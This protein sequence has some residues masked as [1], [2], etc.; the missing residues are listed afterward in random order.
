M[1]SFTLSHQYEMRWNKSTV[2]L[3]II[4]QQYTLLRDSI[5]YS[6]L[7]LIDIDRLEIGRQEKE[8]YGDSFAGQKIVNLAQPSKR[9]GQFFQLQ[10]DITAQFCDSLQAIQRKFSDTK[11]CHRFTILKVDNTIVISVSL[12]KEKERDQRL[13]A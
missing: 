7:Y 10:R 9:S 1:N 2:K 3:T 8:S 13:Q 6:S 12:T 5:N 11:T 4:D